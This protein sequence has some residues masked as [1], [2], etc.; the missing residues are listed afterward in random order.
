MTTRTARWQRLLRRP[1]GD[2]LAAAEAIARLGLARLAIVRLP[3]DRLRKSFGRPEHEA[4]PTSLDPDEAALVKQVRWAVL[5][6]SRLTPWTS[7]CL[8]QA[9]AAKHMLARRGL[10]STLY[11]GAAF[12][13]RDALHAHAWLRCGDVAVTGGRNN[14]DRFGAVIAYS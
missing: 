13:G 4:A 11:V 10:E 12:A 1:V 7:D 2:W 14:E 9:L 8:P 5:G 6:I 3:S